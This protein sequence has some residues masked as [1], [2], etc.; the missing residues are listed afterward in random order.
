GRMP[1]HQKGKHSWIFKNVGQGPLDLR[2]ISSSCSC[3]LA[4]FKDE[5]STLTLAPGESTEIVLSWDT[6]DKLHTYK[7]NAVIGTSDPENPEV[8][9]QVNGE[10]ELT[11][12]TMPE[13]H[14]IP[15]GQVTNNEPHTL[16]A[17]VMSPT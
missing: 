14:V 16:Q 6:K 13:D 8:I 12:V 17:A 11:I 9:L 7:Q 5:V 1:Q 4:N 3:T 10:V 15:F 2:K